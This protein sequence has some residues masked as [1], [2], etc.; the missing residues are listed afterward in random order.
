MILAGRVS[1]YKKGRVSWLLLRCLEAAATEE[2]PR[3]LN[4]QLNKQ[5][6]AKCESQR[7]CLV[8]YKEALISCS[9]EANRAEELKQDLIVCVSE[10]QRHSKVQPRLAVV[11]RSNPGWKIWPLKWWDGDIWTDALGGASAEV[12]H[13][14]LVRVSTPLCWMVLQRLLLTKPLGSCARL[15]LIRIKFQDVLGL[16]RKERGCTMRAVRLS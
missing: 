11:L 2:K 5:L 4:K 12:A 16:I 7:V 13:L 1:V 15:S 3:V 14:F 6:K 9:G 8:V 10:F